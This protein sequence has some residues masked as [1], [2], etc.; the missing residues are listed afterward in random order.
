LP[1]NVKVELDGDSIGI[2]G[3]LGSLTR[4]F[5]RQIEIEKK[6]DSLLVKVVK[7]DKTTNAIQ[8]SI[9]AHLLNMIKGVTE[10]WTKSLEIVG[11]GYRASSQGDELTL[12]LGY[13]HPVIITAP[14]DLKVS[15]E[16][17]IIKV[18]GADKEKV[19]EMAAKI[20]ST[21]PPEPY[22]GKGIKYLDEVIRRKA[23]KQAAKAE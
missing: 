7:K 16:K 2:T 4:S 13:S 17:S 22:K 3:P 21:R 8:G 6:D 11:V 19:G 15:V 1:T 18:E 5:P 23:G 12:N 9:R 10:G 14:K 20:R